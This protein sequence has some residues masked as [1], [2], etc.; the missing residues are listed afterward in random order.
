MPG[1]NG[2]LLLE[3]WE[4]LDRMSGRAM[5]GRGRYWMVDNVGTTRSHRG[6]GIASALIRTAL[7]EYTDRGDGLPVYLDTSGDEDGRVWPL[8]ERLGFARVGEFEIDLTRHGG[9]GS[10]R[11]FGMMRQANGP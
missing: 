4:K 3:L 6:R 5:A 11:R 7:A 8:Y 2:P 10:H 9:E 1:M